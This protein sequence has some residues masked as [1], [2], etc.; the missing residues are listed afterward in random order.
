MIKLSTTKDLLNRVI[1]TIK[2]IISN[3][4][5][6]EKVTCTSEVNNGRLVT[7]IEII[8]RNPNAQ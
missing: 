2:T 3:A 7:R 8:S 5:E 4:Q 1:L 6:V